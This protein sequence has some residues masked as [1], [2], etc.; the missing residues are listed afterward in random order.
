MAKVFCANIYRDCSWR[1]LDGVCCVASDKGCDCQTVVEDKSQM[2][3]LDYLV[4]IDRQNRVLFSKK[5]KERDETMSMFPYCKKY[6]Y[7]EKY[8]A[9]K[10]MNDDGGECINGP[11][12]RYQMNLSPEA[13]AILDNLRILKQQNAEILALYQKQK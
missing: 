11:L 13:F 8:D 6:F 10:H 3:I 7:P 5:Q 1:S 4:K 12:C 2:L 9:C